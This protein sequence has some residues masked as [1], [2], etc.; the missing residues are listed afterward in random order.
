MAKIAGRKVSNEMVQLLAP[1]QL[2][3]GVS[4]GAEAAVHAARQYLQGMEQGDAVVKLDFTNAFNSVRRDYVATSRGFSESSSAISWTR[5][6][7]C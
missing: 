4:G 5:S 3:F 1:R 6:F 7:K 2:G